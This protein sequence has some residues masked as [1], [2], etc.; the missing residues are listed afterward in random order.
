LSLRMIACHPRLP[1]AK[2]PTNLLP[3]IR[4]GKTYGQLMKLGVGVNSCQQKFRA[5]LLW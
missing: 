1:K 5:P 4:G 2:N 3:T